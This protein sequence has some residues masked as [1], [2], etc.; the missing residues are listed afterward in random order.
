MKKR[1][2]LIIVGIIILLIAGVLINVYYVIPR[3]DRLHAN[4]WY[5][6][7]LEAVTRE[8]AEQLNPKNKQVWIRKYVY[9]EYD[10]N[11]EEK[12]KE[13]DSKEYPFTKVD[14]DV[15]IGSV[16]YIFHIVKDSSGKLY[17]ESHELN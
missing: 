5:D 15:K 2:V 14:A 8:Y 3:V 17:V 11:I 9:V 1:G 7:D 10:V 6:E 12:N 4:R 16:Y 13:A